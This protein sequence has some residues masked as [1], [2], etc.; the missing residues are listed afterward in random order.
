MALN[1]SRMGGKASHVAQ[2]RVRSPKQRLRTKLLKFYARY[3]ADKMKPAVFNPILDYFVG[4][5]EM[6]NE[7][8]RKAHGLPSTDQASPPAAAES[9]VSLQATSAGHA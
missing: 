9:E 6:L 1:A 7:H 5:E 8:L 2:E 3:N 4:R